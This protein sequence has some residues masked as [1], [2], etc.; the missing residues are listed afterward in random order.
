MSTRLEHA[1]ITVPDIDAAISFLKL[2][3]PAFVVR[4]DETPE[5]SYR[6][7]HIGNDDFYIALQQSHIGSTPQPPHRAYTNY[8]VNHLAWVV[9]DLGGVIERLEAAGCKQSVEAVTHPHRKHAYYF[10]HSGMEWEFIEYLSDNPEERNE[11]R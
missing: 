6:W 3:D 4:R 7:V 8:G 10:D 2:I 1:N 9:D 11:Y 5:G